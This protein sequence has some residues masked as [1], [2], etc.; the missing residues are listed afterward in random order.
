MLSSTRPPATRGVNPSLHI[1]YTYYSRLTHTHA[2]CTYCTR[3]ESCCTC[4]RADLPFAFVRPRRPRPSFV[5]FYS[6][7]LHY[8]REVVLQ[9][10][11]PADFRPS[12]RVLLPPMVRSQAYT[13]PAAMEPLPICVLR[14]SVPAGRGCASSFVHS[15]LFILFV[16]FFVFM[17]SRAATEPPDFRP[18]PQAAAVH[19]E[20]DGAGA[21]R[22]VRYSTGVKGGWVGGTM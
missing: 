1:Q 15:C 7:I 18:S 5:H 8:L 2:A 21:L 17:R 13:L 22:E 19:R 6:F 14:W 9:L 4:A 3:L 11:R 12:P 16:H 10:S 20:Y